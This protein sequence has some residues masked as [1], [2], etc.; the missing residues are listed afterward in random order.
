MEIRWTSIA[1]IV[2]VV[3]K[4][5]FF[6]CFKYKCINQFITVFILECPNN[7]KLLLTGVSR[8]ISF[9]SGIPHSIITSVSMESISMDYEDAMVY[10]ILFI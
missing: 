8:S 2:I 4:A 10:L 6:E 1:L 9:S 5:C 7:T 3:L